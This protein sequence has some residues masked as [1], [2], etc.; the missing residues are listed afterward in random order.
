MPHFNDENI[1]PRKRKLT[2]QGQGAN[3]E[4]AKTE[5]R[6]GAARPGVSHR[7][8]PRP[9]AAGSQVSAL[10][11]WG[12]FTP[13]ITRPALQIPHL[14]RGAGRGHPSLSGGT[15]TQAP[16]P[17]PPS[18]G[19]RARA[20]PAHTHRRAAARGRAGSEAPRPF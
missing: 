2:I 1:K 10:W 15:R 19:T 14:T 20:R 17:Q 9:W 7:T 8:W 6:L 3:P 12:S 4:G 11:P 16:R 18:A 13:E 5:N